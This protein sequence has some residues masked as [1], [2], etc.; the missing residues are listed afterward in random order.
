MVE[1]GVLLNS[2]TPE[3][4]PGYKVMPYRGMTRTDNL[5]SGDLVID[6]I[7]AFDEGG[8]LKQPDAK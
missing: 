1:L 5:N 2:Y 3:T 7:V 8:I 6:D 4:A